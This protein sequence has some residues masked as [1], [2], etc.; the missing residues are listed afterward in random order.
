MNPTNH[1]ETAP[2]FRS[3]SILLFS[4]FLF[5]FFAF[6]WKLGHRCACNTPCFCSRRRCPARRSSNQTGYRGGGGE[7]KNQHFDVV[8]MALVPCCE[9]QAVRR[10]NAACGGTLPGFAP[11]TAHVPRRARNAPL[12]TVVIFA[13]MKGQ[14]VVFELS[15][16]LRRSISCL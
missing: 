14:T 12:S 13:V 8:S 10:S 7:Q 11:S 2:F 6:L 15:Y 16:F 9:N 1:R 5:F 4:R 3:P